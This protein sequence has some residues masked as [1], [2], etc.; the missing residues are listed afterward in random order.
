MPRG[1]TAL[2][3]GSTPANHK[4]LQYHLRTPRDHG[5]E[6]GGRLTM[7]NLQKINFS[8]DDILCT[9]FESLLLPHVNAFWINFMEDLSRDRCIPE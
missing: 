2:G 7:S 9:I 6:Q 8:I 1:R 3:G 4:K 5:I